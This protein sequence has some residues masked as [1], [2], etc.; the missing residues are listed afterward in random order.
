V[1]KVASDPLLGEVEDDL[2]GAVDELRRLADPLTSEARDL[3]PGLDERPKGRRLLDDLRVVVDVRR[4]RHQRRKLGDAGAAADLLELAPLL[5]LL[6]ERDRV[7]RLSLRPEPEHRAVDRPVR[8]AVEVG[9]VEDLRDGPDCRLGEEHRAEHGLLGLEVLRR[10]ERRGG[11]M[12]RAH[13]AGLKPSAAG[14]S[15]STGPAE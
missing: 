6:R 12:R 8:P 10:D 11:S 9:G 15:N 2:L 14:V 4:G 3:L 7:D 1:R 5:Q 13:G